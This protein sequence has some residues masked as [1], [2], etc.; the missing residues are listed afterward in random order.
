MNFH[1]RTRSISRASSSGF[2]HWQEEG[3][4]EMGDGPVEYLYINWAHP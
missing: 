2:C 4:M 3:P 1:I